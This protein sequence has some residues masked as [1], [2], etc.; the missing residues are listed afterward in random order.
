MGASYSQIVESLKEQKVLYDKEK[1]WN[2]NMVARI[3]EDRRY[4]GTS[5][6]PPLISETQFSAVADKRRKKAHP[7]QKTPAQKIMR[8]LCG[9]TPPTWVEQ[10]MLKLLNRLILEPDIVCNPRPELK[11]SSKNL[12]LQAELDAKMR[13]LPIDEEAS[14]QLI[15][16]LAA[17]HYDDLGNGAYETNRIHR[18]LESAALMDYPEETLLHALIR[19][20]T[21]QESHTIMSN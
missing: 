3:L 10:Y 12:E 8:R 7:S 6:F 4:I 14:K 2:K 13:C 18:M 17:A 16:R 5:E 20:I 21:I 15:F 1:L 19:R 9:C 11:V